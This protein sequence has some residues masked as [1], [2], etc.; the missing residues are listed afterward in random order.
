MI[1]EYDSKSKTSVILWESVAEPHP[2]RLTFKR[3][4]NRAKAQRSFSYQADDNQKWYGAASVE[5]LQQR[6][7]KG[8]AEGVKK[9]E[10]I[11]IKELD[12][13]LSVRR[14][15]IRAD[16]GDEVDMQAVWRGDL[17]RAWTKTRR[18][19]RTGVRS[20]S[21]IIDLGASAVTS[22]EKLFWRGASALRLADQLLTAGYS[23]AIYG[24]ATAIGAAETK[25]LN[26]IQFVEIKAEDAPFDMDKLAALTAMPGFFR[27]SLFAGINYSADRIDDDTDYGYGQADPEGKHIPIALKMLPSIPQ[28][29]IIQPPSVLNKEAAEA[30]LAQ[31]IEQIEAPMLEAA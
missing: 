28:N 1:Y 26:A 27:T 7:T 5:E 13:P 29:A 30:W 22:S 15:R 31:A 24:A 4:S 19:N 8:W 25:K 16:Q 3:D 6:L 17:S 18:A 12:A 21:I 10:A 23:V 2:D 20:L 11:A 14:R 9:L